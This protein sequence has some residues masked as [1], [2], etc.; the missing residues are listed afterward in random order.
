[1]DVN[2]QMIEERGG[3]NGVHRRLDG[4]TETEFLYGGASG[5]IPDDLEL[6]WGMRAEAKRWLPVY[7]GGRYWAAAHFVASVYKE[8]EWFVAESFTINQ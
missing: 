4:R 5:A 8:G 6:I 7:Y 2:E 3:T 1:M